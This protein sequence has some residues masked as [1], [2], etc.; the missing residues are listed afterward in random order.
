MAATEPAGNGAALA[1]LTLAALALPG[2]APKAQADVSADIQTNFSRYEESG[3]RMKIDTYQALAQVRAGDRWTLR[4]NG[5]KDV[6]TGASPIG[7]GA[8][9]TCGK[10]P[11]QGE[12]ILCMSGASI[13]DVRDAVDIGANYALDEGSIGV[14][15]GRSF[16]ND[17]SSTFFNIDGRWDLNRKTA[18][19]VAGYGYA[20]DSVWAVQHIDGRIV[21]EFDYAKGHRV[22]GDKDTHQGLLGVTQILDKN[23]LAQANLTYTHNAGFLADPYKYA[24]VLNAG[25][26][27]PYV[28]D[29]R[30][31]NREQFGVLLRYV[32]YFDSLNGAALHLD[33]RFY[34]DTWGIDSHQFEAAWNQPLFDGWLLRPRI[35][36]YTQTAADFYQPIYREFRRDGLYSSDYRMAHFGAIAGGVQ[37]SKEFFDRLRVAGGVDFYERR[38]GLAL[39]Q[40]AG[41]NLDN[42]SYSMFSVSLNLKF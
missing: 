13:R 17:Y 21:R 41:S 6:V 37:I 26:A 10:G 25:F 3:N 32:R 11:V 4:A 34:S 42:F 35:R 38:K 2:M 28:R 5:V 19:L 8:R 1:A 31:G 24:Y 40:G 22:G 16:E 23:S 9:G 15:A 30:P 7:I 14:D 39:S 29:N 27:A 18:T 36:Y 33:Y 20:S 12:R